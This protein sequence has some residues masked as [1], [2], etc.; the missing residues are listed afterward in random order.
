MLNKRVCRM[1]IY[2]YI[3]YQD[4][5]E[6]GKKGESNHTRFELYKTKVSTQFNWYR[7]FLYCHHFDCPI[8]CG[9]LCLCLCLYLAFTHI[10]NEFLVF[11]VTKF[12][13][14]CFFVYRQI[15][16]NFFSIKKTSNYWPFAS[17][18]TYLSA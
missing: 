6:M 7:H 17:I 9:S 14:Y 8:L 5:N 11:V 18:S 16:F 2:I 13:F 3:L 4:E 10:C 1:K 12:E 15:H